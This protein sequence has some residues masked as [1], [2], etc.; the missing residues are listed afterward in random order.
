MKTTRDKY[1]AASGRPERDRERETERETERERQRERQRER[2]RERQR[3][4]QR[5]RDRKR[6]L[7]PRLYLQPVCFL[8]LTGGNGG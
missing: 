4:R 8:S 6:D 3:E 1:K 7:A 2:D 5:Q